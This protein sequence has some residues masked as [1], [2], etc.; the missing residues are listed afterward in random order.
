MP[1]AVEQPKCRRGQGLQKFLAH[2]SSAAKRVQRR[3]RVK[4][5]HHVCTAVQG[6]RKTLFQKANEKWSKEGRREGGD[7]EERGAA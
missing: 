1:G 3:G 4:P 2:E 6:P 5:D 7:G